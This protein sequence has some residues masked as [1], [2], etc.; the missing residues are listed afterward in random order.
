MDGLASL[1]AAAALFDGDDCSKKS[2]RRKKKKEAKEEDETAE[3]TLLET[4]SPSKKRKRGKDDVRDDV[5][6]ASS[7]QEVALMLERDSK[8][9]KYSGE[10]AE[11]RLARSL[12]PLARLRCIYEWFYSTI[13]RDY[14]KENE[15]LAC[16]NMMGLHQTSTI[17]KEEWS[18]VRAFMGSSIGRPRRFSAAF[19]RGEIDKLE[20]YRSQVRRIQRDPSNSLSFTQEFPY[21]VYH[22]ARVGDGV[23][24]FH[25][26]TCSLQRGLVL[27]LNKTESESVA[28]RIQFERADLGNM[29]VQDTDLA[30]HGEAEV[31]V[32]HER[33]G[34]MAM[35]EDQGSPRVGQLT[36]EDNKTFEE[37]WLNSLRE[38][39]DIFREIQPDCDDQSSY[40][41]SHFIAEAKNVSKICVASLIF[42]QQ[43]ANISFKGE[44]EAAVWSANVSAFLLEIISKEVPSDSELQHKLS[45][46]FILSQNCIRENALGV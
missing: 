13:D 5:S 45:M 29:I 25:A 22:P 34:E 8:L 33:P 36:L 40:Q 37:S 7:M 44:K 30:I 6:I 18:A 31:L 38:A 43:M 4:S 35:L 17:T 15:F 19:L 32:A 21:Q 3:E 20:Q 12:N 14:F 23:S 27:S 1:A 24:A 28:Y 42:L 39:N 46:L 11:G 16:L 9:S 2:K 41:T 26:P 10:G